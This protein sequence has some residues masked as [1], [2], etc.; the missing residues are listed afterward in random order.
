M[1]MMVMMV[2]MMMMM[3]MMMMITGKE[4]RMI[5]NFPRFDVMKSC[6]IQ[7]GTAQQSIFTNFTLIIFAHHSD[8]LTTKTKVAAAA[9]T[10]LQS[11]GWSSVNV[12]F[13]ICFIN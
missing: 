6:N 10:E 9:A 3:M 11:Y 2:I 5:H 7:D 8:R 4:R 1:L 12:Y 13:C